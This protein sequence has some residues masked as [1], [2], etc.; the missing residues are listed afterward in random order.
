M[1]YKKNAILTDGVFLALNLF[2]MS[3]AGLPTGVRYEKVY[4]SNILQ[5]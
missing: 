1:A 2:D 5:R 4:T 3:G